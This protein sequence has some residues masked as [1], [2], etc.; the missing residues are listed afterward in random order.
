MNFVDLPERLSF[1]HQ[2]TYSPVLIRFEGGDDLSG[3]CIH[4]YKSTVPTIDMYGDLSTARE[5]CAGALQHI[6]DF[7]PGM[8]DG[9]KGCSSQYT[10]KWFILDVRYPH[11]VAG[12]TFRDGHL[13]I[14]PE[15]SHDW[16]TVYESI[17]TAY[18]RM[19][20]IYR[21]VYNVV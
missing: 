21:A 1:S 10:S 8:C 17:K 7:I 16:A 20:A 13:R 11:C 4:E 3:F 6:L 9:F 2:G 19:T 18:A 5:R 15:G 12:L 14:L